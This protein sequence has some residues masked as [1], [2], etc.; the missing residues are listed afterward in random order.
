MDMLNTEMILVWKWQVWEIATEFQVEYMESLG[1][2]KFP[3]V[4]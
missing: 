2:G 3:A 4:T 1:K